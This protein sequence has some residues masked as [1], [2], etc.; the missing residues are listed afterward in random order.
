[1]TPELTPAQ[2]T[3]DASGTPY[4]PAFDDCYFSRLDGLAESRYVFLQGNNLPQRWQQQQRFVIAETG[5][6]TGL[7]FLAT[8]QAWQQ[9]GRG[10]ECADRCDGGHDCSGSAQAGAVP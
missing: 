2:V 5:F 7:S 10:C 1:M 4:A 3:L 9:D 8:W 6:G